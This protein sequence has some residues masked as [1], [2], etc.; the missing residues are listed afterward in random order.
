MEMSALDGLAGELS[1]LGFGGR[2]RLDY[3]TST[4]PT[5]LP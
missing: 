1:L 3:E 5:V 4:D 2:A